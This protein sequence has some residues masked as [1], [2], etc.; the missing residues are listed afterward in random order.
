M[1][2]IAPTVRFCSPLGQ[3][4]LL[5]RT[6]IESVLSD[7]SRPFFS[8]HRPF[9]ALYEQTLAQKALEVANEYTDPALKQK[10]TNAALRFRIPYWDWASDPDIPD[11]VAKQQ[12]IQLT[13]PT[14]VQTI[15]NPVYSY[16]FP[17]LYSDFADGLPDEKT[18]RF[19][20]PR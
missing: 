1:E 18:V 8:R 19:P 9:L 12:S 11:L 14:G 3:R 13:T 20:H 16:T 17:P 10:Y 5:P 6:Y 7:S 4:P 2:D 15:P